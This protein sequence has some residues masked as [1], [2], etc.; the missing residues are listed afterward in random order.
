MYYKK[1]KHNLLIVYCSVLK[2]VTSIFPDI[3]F[4]MR[5][6]GF[7]Y[8]IF[9]SSHGR[10]LQ[11]GSN[12]TIKGLEC[13][14]FG[15]DVFIANNVNIYSRKSIVIEDEVL[16]G[17]NVVVVDGNHGF[18]GASYRYK[19]GRVGEVRI[20][21]G[22]WIGANSVVLH[23]TTIGAGTVIGACSVVSGSYDENSVYCSKLPV[24]VS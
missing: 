24:K 4:L 6:R 2:V 19:K 12:V 20:G 1:L 21:S 3:P 17:P 22:S 16:L 10:N 13:I 7:L 14:Y 23:S 5:L 11:I 9:A 18:D 15:N 8:S